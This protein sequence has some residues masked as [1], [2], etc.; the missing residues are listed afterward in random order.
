M[1][2]NPYYYT[3]DSIR[4]NTEKYLGT[5]KRIV[6]SEVCFVVLFPNCVLGTR[7]EIEKH[8]CFVRSFSRDRH[9]GYFME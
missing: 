3:M 4:S 1:N 5:L 9:T 8:S 6:V 2:K 7:T